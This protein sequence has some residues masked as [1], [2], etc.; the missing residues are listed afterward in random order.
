MPKF[1][2]L[3]DVQDVF[4]EFDGKLQRVGFFVT[5]IVDADKVED[6]FSIAKHA[7]EDSSTFRAAI[8]NGPENPP[9]FVLEEH[10]AIA[11]NSDEHMETG[12]MFYDSS[13]N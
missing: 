13:S 2:L 6:A 10:E 1:K 11:A 5:R 7:L 12:F 9:R 3:I 4:A 8:R